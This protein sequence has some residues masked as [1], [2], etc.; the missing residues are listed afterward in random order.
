MAQLLS[1]TD[2]ELIALARDIEA[3]Q[4]FTMGEVPLSD[5]EFLPNIFSDVRSF[6][7]GLL[8]QYRDK[9]IEGVNLNGYPIF[10]ESHVLSSEQVVR[11]FIL[12]FSGGHR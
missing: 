3:G 5:Q 2:E 10:E 12:L 1:M 9:A 8:Y 4:V 6:E 7:E 11:T